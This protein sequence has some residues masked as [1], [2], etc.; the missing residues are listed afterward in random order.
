MRPYSPHNDERNYD[1]KQ[2]DP[3]GLKDLPF[4]SEYLS[5]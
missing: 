4:L 3:Y 2:L 5:I 1:K